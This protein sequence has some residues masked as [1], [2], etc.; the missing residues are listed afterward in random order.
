MASPVDITRDKVKTWLETFDGEGRTRS[1]LV[2]DVTLSPADWE[3]IFH[4]ALDYC[5]DRK[6]EF[7][8]ER[9]D[10]S[11]YMFMFANKPV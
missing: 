5:A 4:L 7:Y 10:K 11:E 3:T 9:A 8:I 6:W 2:L 1:I